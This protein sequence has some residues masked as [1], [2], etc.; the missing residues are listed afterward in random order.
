MIKKF[1]S[2]K[3]QPEADPPSAEKYGSR[4]LRQLAEKAEVVRAP[5]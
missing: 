2:P 1:S 5:H 4:L 3:F